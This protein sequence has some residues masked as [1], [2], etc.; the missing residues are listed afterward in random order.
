[1]KRIPTLFF[2]TALSVFVAAAGQAEIVGTVVSTDPTANTVVVT[3]PDGRQMVYRTMETTT[4]RQGD[5]AVQL[6]NL[7]PGAKVQIITQP[8]PP[9]ATGTTVVHPVAS[10]IIVTSPAT[11]TTVVPVPSAQAPSVSSPPKSDEG[12]VK[13]DVPTDEDADV[14]V[15]VED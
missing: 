2:A 4:I 5:T 8:A 1:M 6:Q 10:G 12:R 11:D 13:V 9:A 7:Q 14:D 15:D 3:T